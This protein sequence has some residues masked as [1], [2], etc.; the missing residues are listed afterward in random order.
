MHYI[1]DENDPEAVLTALREAG[2]NVDEA[3]ESGALVMA[4]AEDSYMWNGSFDPDEM[5]SIVFGMIEDGSEEYEEVRIT[6]ETTW[7]LHKF[8]AIPGYP[9]GNWHCEQTVITP[10]GKYYHSIT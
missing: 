10:L 4:T 8:T 5:V 9:L 1:V 7:A 2:T 3:I 6:G